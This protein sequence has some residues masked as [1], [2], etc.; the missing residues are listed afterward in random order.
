MTDHPADTTPDPM[1]AELRAMEHAAALLES[2]PGDARR[3]AVRWLTQ[4]FAPDLLN[5][6]ERAYL[7]GRL[8]EPPR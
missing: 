3:R 7:D 4:R 5:V 6:R 1:T 2:L 8:T